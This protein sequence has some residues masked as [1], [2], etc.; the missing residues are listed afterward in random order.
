MQLEKISTI[1]KMQ[2]GKIL[3]VKNAAGEDLNNKENAA[4]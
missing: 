1:K 3:T 2:L 4:R